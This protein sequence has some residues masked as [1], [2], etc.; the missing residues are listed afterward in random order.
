MNKF[1]TFGLGAAAVVV[2][3]LVGTQ[4][5][6]SPSDGGVGAQP[7]ATPEATATPQPT[8]SASPDPDLE[9]GPFSLTDGTG[10]EGLDGPAIT[11]TIAAPG[12]NGESGS[13]LLVK[14]NNPNP[15]NGA[16]LITFTSADGYYVYGDPCQWSS[17]RPDTPASTVDELVSALSAQAS[18]DASE[19]VDISVDG[20]AGKAITLHVPD[21]AIFSEC[22]QGRFGSW[23]LGTVDLTPHRFH[24]GPGQIDNMWIL[25]VEGHVVVL[26]W[27]HYAGTP[28]AD[29]DEL[30]AIVESATFELP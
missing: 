7:T 11:V 27:S 12:W 29:V 4:F 22:D 5:F 30:Q 18:R 15:P 23:S 21:D 1:V 8:T 19:P 24:Q 9:P 2:V 13:G 17:T 6:G 26:D 14:N 20:Y 16:G 3:L 28:Q 25:D 10:G